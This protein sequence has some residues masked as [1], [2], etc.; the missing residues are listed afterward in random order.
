MNTYEYCQNKVKLPQINKFVFTEYFSR[1][2]PVLVSYNQ[3]TV[4]GEAFCK[5]NPGKIAI[6]LY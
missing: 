4:K 2:V 3:D 5:S 6:W 1:C